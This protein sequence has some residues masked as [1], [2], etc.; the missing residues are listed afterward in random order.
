M[1]WAS[2]LWTL[3]ALRLL[4]MATAARRGL[5][6]VPAP[7]DDAPE[8]GAASDH[9]AGYT[10]VATAGAILSDRD[11]AAARRH[12]EAEGLDVVHL[13]PTP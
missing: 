12:A 3:I 1:T 9:A 11:V 13:R 6:S 4:A 8:T 5:Q 10:L 2:I 7:R